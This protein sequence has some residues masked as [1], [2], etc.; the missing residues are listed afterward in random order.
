[1]YLTS[2]L[3]VINENFD[4][5]DTLEDN[6]KYAGSRIE[7]VVYNN[8]C[9]NEIVLSYLKQLA[10]KFIDNSTPIEFTFSECI[11]ELLRVAS[12]EYIC[13][14]QDYPLLCENWL[15]K[16]LIS[17]N[18]I[19][20]SGVISINEWSTNEIAYHLDKNDNLQATYSKDNL[21]N[22]LPFFRKDLIYSIGGFDPQ[23]NGVYAIWD[24]CNRTAINGYYNY[25]V[26]NTSMIKEN[27]YNDSY[28]TNPAFYKRYSASKNQESFIPIFTPSEQTPVV[29]KVIKKKINC[30]I[31]YS[32]KLGAIVFVKPYLNSEDLI[33]LSQILNEYQLS[34]ELF[35]SSTYEENILKNSMVGIIR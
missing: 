25:F 23:L 7:L 8:H 3:L 31:Q 19:L 18:E 14:F 27:S 24:F 16:L 17:H 30:S 22:G 28:E 21:V 12:G 34:I 26:P 35:S 9:K 4:S 2:V 20:K 11:N 13:V 1:M 10:T 33:V 5:V 6:I 32:V 29:M 15:Q